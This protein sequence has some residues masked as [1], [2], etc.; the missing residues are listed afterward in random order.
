MFVTLCLVVH[1]HVH[2]L[3]TYSPHKKIKNIR[4]EMQ[5]WHGKKYAYLVCII[6]GMPSLHLFT[7]LMFFLYFFVRPKP[8][9]NISFKYKTDHASF[10]EAV[11]IFSV[12]VGHECSTLPVWCP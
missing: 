6:Y 11:S 9:M 4:N 12:P 10:T 7:F 2:A 1:V 8:K 5:S 3:S